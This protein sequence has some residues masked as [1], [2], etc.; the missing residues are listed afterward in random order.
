MFRIFRDLLAPSSGRLAL[1][2]I[3]FLYE[4]LLVVRSWLGYLA[5]EK[6]L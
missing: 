1:T 3:P 5:L 4:Q 2:P 6:S